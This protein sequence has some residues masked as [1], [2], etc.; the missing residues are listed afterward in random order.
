MSQRISILFGELITDAAVQRA[1][2]LPP[3]VYEGF[4]PSIGGPS[5]NGGWAVNLAPGPRSI[6]IW[7][8]AGLPYLGSHTIFEDGLVSVQV[9]GPSSKA[10]I[11]LVIGA[12]HWVEGPV[13]VATGYPVATQTSD[14][15]AVYGVVKGTPDDIP[16][17]PPVPNPYDVNGRRAVILAQV[18][19]PP[20]GAPTVKRWPQTD[21]RLGHRGLALGNATLNEL[22]WHQAG[23]IPPI[24]R[25]VV[26]SDIGSLR[27]LSRLQHTALAIVAGAGI[28]QYDSGNT[29]ADDGL[30]SV[31]PISAEGRWIR[32]L[33]SGGGTGDTQAPMFSGVTI[34]GNTATAA[35]S[36][37]T[38]VT[39]VEFYVDNSLKALVNAAPWTATLDLTGLTGPHALTAKAFDAAGN[40]AVSSSVAFTPGGSASADTQAPVVSASVSGTSGTIS[41]SATASDNLGVTKVEFYV[42]ATQVGTLSAAPY[43]MS[44]ESNSLS[45]G[46][47]TLT[48]KGYD[49]AGNVGSSNTVT[50]T[51]SNGPTADTTPPTISELAAVP[52]ETIETYVVLSADVID[53]QSG[54]ALVVFLVDGAQK[55]T[56]IEAP[57]FFD[58]VKGLSAGS[59][60]FQVRATDVAGNTSTKSKAFSVAAGPDV[61]GPVVSNLAATYIGNRTLRF[62]CTATDDVGVAKVDFLFSSM[63]VGTVDAPASGNTYSLDLP[64]SWQLDGKTDI[65][66]V[67]TAFDAAGNS[68]TAVISNVSIPLPD[69]T[70]SNLRVTGTDPDRTLAVDMTS[71]S[72]ASEVVYSVVDPAGV[73][74]QFKV[75]AA[76]W[77]QGFATSVVG[78]YSVSAAVV[79]IQGVTGP[80][81]GPVT[82]THAEDTTAPVVSLSPADGSSLSGS[83]QVSA[84]ATDNGGVTHLEVQIGGQ[85]YS[86]SNG[87][88]ISFSLD[89]QILANGQHAITAIATDA[90]GNAGQVSHTVNVNNVF[91]DT[92]NPT[93]SISQSTDGAGRIT[94]TAN[95][96]DNVGV[97]HVF[98]VADGTAAGNGGSLVVDPSGFD[99]GLHSV[100]ATA[101]DAAGNQ[102]SASAT[103][104]G[105]DITGGGGGGCFAPGT[106][107]L[108]GNG[109]AKRIEEIQVGDQVLTIHERAHQSETPFLLEAPVDAVLRHAGAFT[110]RKIEGISATPEHPWGTA[111]PAWTP[112]E[113]LQAGVQVRGIQ[114]GI[115][116]WFPV[117]SPAPGEVVPTVYN[118][119][120]RGARTY[121]VAAAPEGPYFLVHNIKIQT[122]Q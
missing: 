5:A 51:I 102:A 8:T 59:H 7:R 28:Y 83:V 55:A 52:S 58:S 107:V 89:T 101:F 17:A 112:T 110:M 32:I 113:G 15:L 31:K 96:A 121:L 108:M 69:P 103:F 65:I 82:F 29:T 27:A 97:D 49:A 106:W 109:R 85:I 6:S 46:T 57:F 67:A 43:A 80:S 44:L 18:M 11:D 73:P 100:Q 34:N 10:R 23:E 64:Y 79:N 99:T 33:G 1:N 62:T 105:T 122:M 60:T 39:R 41:L 76:P 12:H 91:A 88:P 22:G 94:F 20:T 74:R 13:D 120:V 36:D 115:I 48:A 19:V 118:L 66:L 26:V 92:T 45:N 4:E 53:V 116:Q 47:H 3:G 9:D 70:I 61:T 56:F 98:W 38:G 2:P 84:S 50:F 81:L 16:Q 117:E 114:D 111:T 40:V 63:F 42:D 90:A 95:A 86:S 119:T 21:M 30:V 72:Q 68:G 93:I 77:T 24:S 87:E 37:N 14:M 75:M 104:Y 78:T 35:V 25:P 71:P 54:V